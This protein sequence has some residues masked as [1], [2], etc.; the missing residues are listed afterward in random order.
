[1]TRLNPTMTSWWLNRVEPTH[2]KK[3]AQVKL[4]HLPK[5]RGENKEYLKPPPR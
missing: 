5:I 4:E 2:L 3:K 1:M